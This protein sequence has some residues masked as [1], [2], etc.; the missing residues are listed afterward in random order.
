MLSKGRIKVVTKDSDGLISIVDTQ[1][2][3]GTLT[4]GRWGLL[5][6]D[7]GEEVVAERLCSLIRD[8]ERKEATQGVPSLQVWT[9]LVKILQVDTDLTVF[10]AFSCWLLLCCPV[11]FLL[12]ATACQ[13]H[14]QHH[15]QLNLQNS[16]TIHFFTA[17]VH[18][19]SQTWIRS[20]LQNP[21]LD[22]Q[23]G[24]H[25]LFARH[26]LLTEAIAMLQV[27]SHV[28]HGCCSCQ[29]QLRQHSPLTGIV[30][31]ATVASRGND[32]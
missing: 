23:S 29:C 16:F 19:E 25:L 5:C 15:C 30:S 10:L 28:H 17:L 3:A 22:S 31:S 8:T 27:S 4:Q 24:A 14:L 2:H 18:L 13:K 11:S 7:K 26:S 1:G 6:A 12:L 9:E 21:L 32:V 20:G